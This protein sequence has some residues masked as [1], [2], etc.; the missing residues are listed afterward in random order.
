MIDP[1]DT[2]TNTATTPA[3]KRQAAYDEDLLVQLV[4]EGRLSFRNDLFYAGL[5]GDQSYGAGRDA[6]PSWLDD[7]QTQMGREAA[8]ITKLAQL[9]LGDA[10]V[11]RQHIALVV[12]RRIACSL[13][14]RE[15]L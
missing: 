2:D 11:V 5:T 6:E 9:R 14:R 1:I 4:A 15:G 8:L 12:R 7:R 10:F 3:P 13:P